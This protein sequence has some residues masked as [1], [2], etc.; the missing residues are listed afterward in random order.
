MQ[1]PWIKIRKIKDRFAKYT[2]YLCDEQGNYFFP[3]SLAPKVVWHIT[4]QTTI[5]GFVIYQN[6]SLISRHVFPAGPVRLKYGDVMQGS[7]TLD[8]L[9]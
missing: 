9:P 5:S 4:T 2:V 8:M 6:G 7:F 3:Q 1:N